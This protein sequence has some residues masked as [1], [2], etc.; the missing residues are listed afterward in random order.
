MTLF[1]VVLNGSP[2]LVY[3]LK[4]SPRD[5]AGSVVESLKQR[6]LICHIVS[7]DA[8]KVVED[9]AN[10]LG[11]EITYIA[12]RA[13]PADKQQY[14]EALQT[15]GKVILFVGDGTN[16][17]VAIAQ[18]NVGAQIG[19]TSDVTSAV[20]DV[21]LLNGLN[22]VVTLL[23]VSKRAFHRIIFNFVW[24]AVYNVF[25]ILLAAGAFVKFR[26]PPG[27]AGLG[28][29][30]SVGPVILAAVTLMFEKRKA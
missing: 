29:I 4:S 8:P 15:S 23:D 14:V 24:T 12:A 2:I 20:A 11:I 13:S 25:A 16:D 28:E 1:C 18:A 27:Y 3:G 10:T 26:I 9:V 30:A 22:G 6:G 19:N 7:G 21:V 17:A 5:E